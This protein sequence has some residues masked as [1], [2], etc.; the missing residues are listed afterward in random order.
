MRMFPRLLIAA[1]LVAALDLAALVLGFVAFN[2]VGGNQ[3]RVQLPVALLLGIAGVALLMRHLRGRGWLPSTLQLLAAALLALPLAAALFLP[4]HR[5]LTGYFS[6]WSN[7]V[8][9]WSVQLPMNLVAT[10]LAVS[11][12]RAATDSS[13]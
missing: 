1:A 12:W 10:L 11:A 7:L 8:A 6:A 2:L 4:A 5:V 9:L 13:A 3:L